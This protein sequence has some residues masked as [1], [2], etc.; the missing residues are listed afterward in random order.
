MCVWSVGE[1]GRGPHAQARPRKAKRKRGHSE[2]CCPK[3]PPE[4]GK[5]M[6]KDLLVDHFLAH[7]PHA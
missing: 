3:V 6:G 5:S 1:L 4:Q 7:K 2:A